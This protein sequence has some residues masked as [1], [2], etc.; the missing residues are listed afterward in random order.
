MTSAFFLSGNPPKGFEQ[1]SDYSH[2]ILKMTLKV[3]W[4]S[5]KG[6]NREMGEDL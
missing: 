1:G 5:D 3:G 4:T 2:F 6:R